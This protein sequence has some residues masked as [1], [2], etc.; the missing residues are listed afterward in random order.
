MKFLKLLSS[1]FYSQDDQSESHH[2]FSYLPKPE[3]HAYHPQPPTSPKPKAT[4]VLFL[5]LDE[6]LS[7]C[8]TS[9]FLIL[10]ESTPD[11]MSRIKKLA[12]K[13]TVRTL[14]M[15]D[16]ES[17]VSFINN[18]SA[19]YKVILS[20]YCD[21]VSIN[22]SAKENLITLL[23]KVDAAIP[24]QVTKVCGSRRPQTPT[25]GWRSQSE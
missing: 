20:R 4:E 23:I 7:F 14:L 22:P 9:D 25:S 2:G 18:L 10:L 5:D 15:R 13:H 11:H 17:L 16:A 24:V 3:D 19:Q 8:S 1:L 12:K 21:G 6:I